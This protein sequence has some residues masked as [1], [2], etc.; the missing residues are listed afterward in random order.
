MYFLLIILLKSLN[1]SMG[2]GRK[3]FS[4]K[5]VDEKFTV[6]IRVLLSKILVIIFMCNHCPYVQAVWGRLNN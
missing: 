4:L 5:G 1:L 2:S 6:A 3:I